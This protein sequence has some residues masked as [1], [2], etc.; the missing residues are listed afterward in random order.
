MTDDLSLAQAASTVRDAVFKLLDAQGHAR[1]TAA[2]HLGLSRSALDTRRTGQ[3]RFYA[4][5]LTRLAHLLGV[6]TD[7]L[8]S[9]DVDVDWGERTV[10]WRAGFAHGRRPLSARELAEHSLGRAFE[11]MVLPQRAPRHAPALHG[12]GEDDLAAS[13]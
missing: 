3:T 10:T 1:V 9:G 2:K 5:E 4:D 11:G 8:S 7:V 12:R 13:G 6:S